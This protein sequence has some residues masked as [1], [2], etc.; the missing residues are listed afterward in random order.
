MLTGAGLRPLGQS[1]PFTS[2]AIQRN[3]SDSDVFVSVSG[4]CGPTP[5]EPVQNLRGVI[6]IV[7]QKRVAHQLQLANFV[8]DRLNL[9]CSYSTF[10][11]GG[12]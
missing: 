2:A 8:P 12:L 7:N 5:G 4:K 11:S 9:F 1:V 10:C 6:A 3:L